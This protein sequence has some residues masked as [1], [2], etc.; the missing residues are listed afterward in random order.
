[1]IAAAVWFLFGAPPI[2]HFAYPETKAGSAAESKAAEKVE[3]KVVE[4]VEGGSPCVR[5][6]KRIPAHSKICP[7]C[8]WNQPS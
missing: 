7:F 4:E 8:G 1:L 3:G 6:G 2:Q 5:C